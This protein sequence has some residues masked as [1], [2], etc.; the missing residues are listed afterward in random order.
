MSTTAAV[1][2]PLAGIY[3]ADPV[4]S[5]FAF[6]VRYMG[7]STFRGTLTSAESRPS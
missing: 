7:V 6:A 1:R 5:S 2:Q 3:T 4:H